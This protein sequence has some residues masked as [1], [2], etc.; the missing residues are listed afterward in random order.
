MWS[1]IENGELVPLSVLN[2]RAKCDDLLRG[3]DRSHSFCEDYGHQSIEEI[4]NALEEIQ[5]TPIE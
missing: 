1:V 4:Q 2:A 5:V 3:H